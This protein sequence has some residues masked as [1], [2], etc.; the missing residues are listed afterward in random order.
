MPKSRKNSVKK[1]LAPV[2]HI[3]CEGE[4]TEPNYFNGY[5]GNRYPGVRRLTVEKTKKNTPK[6]LVEEAVEAKNDK[7]CPEDDIFWVVF[8][9]ESDDKYQKCLHQ[10]AYQSAQNYGV[11]IALSNVSFEVWILLHFQKNTTAYNSYDDLRKN[12]HLCK[13]YIKNYQKGDK[14]IIEMIIDRTD[15]A[16]TNAIE[17]NKNTIESADSSWTMPYQWN[18]YSDVY[19]LLDAMEKFNNLI[20]T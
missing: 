6:Q 16:R 18:P 17:M 9:R 13:K 8:D 10:E 4:K 19:K 7:D 20:F 3:Y 5:I 1:R 15:D 14:N 11:N 2:F 12:S